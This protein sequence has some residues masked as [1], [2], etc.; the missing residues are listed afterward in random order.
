LPRRCRHGTREGR[1]RRWRNQ[2]LSCRSGRAQ[3]GF[4]MGNRPHDLD[5]S[6]RQAEFSGRAGGI[7]FNERAAPAYLDFVYGAFTIGMTFQVSDTNLTSQGV[8]RTA[9][10]HGL[11]SLSVRC[12]ASDDDQ[13]R[14]E[15]IELTKPVGTR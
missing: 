1:A 14:G 8:R 12:R 3:R 7:N 13:R 15:P 6:I 10:R 5:P 2:G 9:L 4:C 11:L